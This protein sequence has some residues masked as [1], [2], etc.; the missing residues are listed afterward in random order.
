MGIVSLGISSAAVLS[1]LWIATEWVPLALLVSISLAAVVA[2]IVTVSRLELENVPTDMSLPVAARTGV[3]MGLTT[4]LLSAGL[5]VVGF[6]WAGTCRWKFSVQP[7]LFSVMPATLAAIIAGT[8]VAALKTNSHFRSAARSFTERTHIGWLWKP[9]TRG[10][11]E[12]K[13]RPEPVDSTSAARLEALPGRKLLAVVQCPEASGSDSIPPFEFRPDPALSGSPPQCWSIHT[14][15]TLPSVDTAADAPAVISPNGIRL[16]CRVAGSDGKEVQVLNLMTLRP[17]LSWR[18]SEAIS[19]IAFSPDGERL[20]FLGCG[21]NPPLSVALIDGTVIP[22]PLIESLPQIDE[23]ME[24]L[25]ANEVIL[26]RRK[27]KALSLNLETLCVHERAESVEAG[28]PSGGQSCKFMARMLCKCARNPPPRGDVTD[29]F[30]ARNPCLALRY[31]A[32]LPCRLF[33]SIELRQGE[34]LMYA[35]GETIALQFKKDGV[36][37]HFFERRESPALD[38]EVTMPHR[39]ELL[40]RESAARNALER[41]ALYTMVYAPLINPLTGKCI[42]PDRNA[43]LG[44]AVIVAWE[45]LKARLRLFEVMDPLPT[46]AVFADPHSETNGSFT[47]AGLQTPHR[48]WSIAA[49]AVQLT[50]PNKLPPAA[51]HANR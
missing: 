27:R 32:E 44:R 49:P 24:W 19:Q 20:L 1:A 39:P 3:R 17:G 45:G 15:K 22:L 37:A 10:D 4:A 43:V 36:T 7:A 41:R 28:K 31:S 51:K 29:W 50:A 46:D 25:Q 33:P 14:V 40:P 34:R 5:L 21:S 2:S 38:C 42:G 6:S 12:L 9:A 30:V 18:F 26:R 47:L 23:S 11:S 8:F 13:P 35:A 48:W 16:A